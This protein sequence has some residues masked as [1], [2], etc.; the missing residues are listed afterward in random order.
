MTDPKLNGRKRG[1]KR[2]PSPNRHVLAKRKRGNDS[3]DSVCD[4]DSQKA[5]SYNLSVEDQ[6]QNTN[7]TPTSRSKRKLFGD[8]KL[9]C[10]SKSE[11]KTKTVG[12]D[13]SEEEL[14]HGNRIIDIELLCQNIS[15]Q[16]V[17]PT[18]KKMC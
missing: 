12:S 9:Y 17:C 10:K 1:T 15:S 7:A 4:D 14:L 11:I 5:T 8:D 16:L 2:K 18:S 6:T 3:V 13:V